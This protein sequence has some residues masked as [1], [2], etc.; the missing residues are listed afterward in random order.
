M[1]QT[2]QQVAAARNMLLS[3]SFRTQGASF[4]LRAK[5]GAT[6]DLTEER[7]MK[8]LFLSQGVHFKLEHEAP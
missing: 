3:S 6:G 5:A 4:L 7:R 8:D 2:F 1:N